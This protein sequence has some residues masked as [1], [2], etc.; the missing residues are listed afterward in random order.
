MEPA[1]IK[2]F[3]LGRTFRQFRSEMSGRGKVRRWKNARQKNV[4][5]RKMSCFPS[6]DLFNSDCYI[7]EV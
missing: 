6:L 2:V 4:R 1:A 7:L 5:R 3:F